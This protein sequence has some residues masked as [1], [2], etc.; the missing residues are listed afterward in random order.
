MGKEIYRLNKPKSLWQAA[1]W[2]AFTSTGVAALAYVG[3][4]LASF[5]YVP[6]DFFD[7]LVRVLPGPLVTLGI[8]TIIR[9]VHFFHAGPTASAAKQA[10]QAIAIGVFIFIGAI[11]GAILSWLG[12]RNASALT[13]YGTAGGLILFFLML[14][15]ELSLGSSQAGFVASAIWLVILLAAW[16]A[17]L[18]RLLRDSVLSIPSNSDQE[19]IQPQRAFPWIPPSPPTQGMSRRTFLYLVIA[20]VATLVLSTLRISQDSVPQSTQPASTGLPPEPVFDTS[21]TSGPAMSPP[22]Q[23]LAGRFLPVTGTR[24]ELTPPADFYR[25]DINLTPPDIDEKTWRLNIDG[26]VDHPLTLSLA[27]LNSRPAYTQAITL[28]CISNNV[29]GDLISTGLWTGVRLKDLM[30]EAGLQPKAQALAI[31]TVDGFYESVSRQDLVDERTLLVYGMDG[32]PLTAEHGF[33]LRL[34]IPDRHG[35][36]LP[37]WIVHI[38]A[39]AADAPGYWV[40][41]GWNRQAIPHTT[42][43]IDTVNIDQAETNG[44]IPVG[45]IAYAGGRGISRVEVQID[46]GPW[47]EAELR[48]PA[49]S[50][51]TWVQWRYFWKSTP[52]KHILR[53]RAYDGTG[54][55]QDATSRPPTPDGAT[56]IYEKTVLVV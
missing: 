4:R 23:E 46:N 22:P 1:F 42:S 13:R 50:P 43:A 40:D 24:P 8:E 51:L 47:I 53:V 38:Q 35:M 27:E 29:G 41:R 9:F 2:G 6:F 39:V 56:G 49:L 37:K 16:G 14:V 55:I 28:E 33:P 12:S 31:Q 34:Y 5:P 3:N 32:Q 30:Q 21:K 18:G 20:G 15:V 11:F 19:T 54:S 17:I 10:E 44:T 26:L 7:W 25:V 48:I 45:G 52:G 36:K